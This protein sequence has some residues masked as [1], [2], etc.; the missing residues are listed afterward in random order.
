MSE[1][2]PCAVNGQPAFFH[3][4]GNMHDENRN[5]ITVAIIED[6]LG[7]VFV[8]RPDSVRFVSM[9]DK[10]ERIKFTHA[11][12]IKRRA[13]KEKEKENGTV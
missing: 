9:S 2:R 7:N 6:V 11:V 3:T 12:I 5:V 4:W 1:T 10:E 8:V 13:A